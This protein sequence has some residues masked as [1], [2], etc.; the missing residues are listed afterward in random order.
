MKG[1]GCCPKDPKIIFISL[2]I[3][4]LFN[5]LHPNISMHIILT[6][7]YTLL[8]VHASRIYLSIKNSLSWWSFPLF[9]TP[10]SLIQG[11]NC[12]EKLD[13]SNS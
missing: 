12:K 6:V 4:Y 13:A 10:S 11:W 5:P 3:F 7:L 9:S 1:G 2:N 8:K